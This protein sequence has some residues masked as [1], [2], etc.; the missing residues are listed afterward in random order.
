MIGAIVD[1]NSP[2][3]K[4]Q[5]EELPAAA[6]ALDRQIKIFNAST[7]SEIDAA[8]AAVAE[9]KIGAVLVT[10]SPFYLPRRDKF[11]ALAA[12]TGCPRSISFELLPKPAG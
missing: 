1:P 5:M 4:L 11:V 2:D 3:T 6:S 7:D 10:S 12:R 9:Q 8:F